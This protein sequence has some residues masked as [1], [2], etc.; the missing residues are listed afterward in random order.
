[1][2][3]HQFLLLLVE[4]V[5]FE[6]RRGEEILDIINKGDDLLEEVFELGPMIKGPA[7]KLQEAATLLTAYGQ[8]FHL[9]IKRDRHRIH[10]ACCKCREI[11]ASLRNYLTFFRDAFS[12][13]EEH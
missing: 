12:A 2:L 4:E 6:L 9:I 11:L 13:S 1:M 8:C 10:V 3:C 5:R 7:G